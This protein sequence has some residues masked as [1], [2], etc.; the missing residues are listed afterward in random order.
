MDQIDWDGRDHELG[1]VRLIPLIL[2]SFG[3]V[4]LCVSFSSIKNITTASSLRV[5][6]PLNKSNRNERW[7]VAWKTAHLLLLFVSQWIFPKNPCP[8]LFTVSPHEGEREKNS[9]LYPRRKSVLSPSQVS[10]QF[11]R[12]LSHLWGVL[13]LLVHTHSHTRNA[14]PPLSLS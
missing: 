5:A 10:P 14:I 7:E 2:W 8:F 3:S 13:I 11:S 12:A 4:G 6:G 9:F 1:I